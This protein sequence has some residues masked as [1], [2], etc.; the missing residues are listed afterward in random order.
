MGD[1]SEYKGLITAGTLL[2]CFAILSMAIPTVL[3]AAE[4]RHV[5]TP[6]D[7]FNIG[8][9]YHYSDDVIRYLNLSGSQY[10]D[11]IRWP[12]GFYA[13]E[14][15]LGGW[16]VNIVYVYPNSTITYELR[17]IHMHREWIILRSDHY[18]EWT[19]S[20]GADRGESVTI[21]ELTTDLGGTSSVDYRASC[22]HFTLYSTVAYNDTLYSSIS[23]AWD[24]GG[25]G[26]FFGISFDDQNT[27]FNAMNLIASILFFQ[28]PE[29]HWAIN[30]LLAIPMWIAI[31][32]ISLI[33]I[34]RA[35][36]ALPFT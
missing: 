3:Y 8:E 5:V 31:G 13:Q 10:L 20:N 1:M 36:D 24:A 28:M 23:D 29:V 27:G 19:T 25:I 12:S 16:E 30:L 2:A 6:P 11:G 33:L 22:D 21:S 7:Y 34:L 15:D 9:L 4:D 17:V 26:V 18:L 35:I 32:Y 14:A